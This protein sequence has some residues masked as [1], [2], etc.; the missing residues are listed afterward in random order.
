MKDDIDPSTLDALDGLDEERQYMASQGGKKGRR[1]K[2]PKGH[3]WLARWLPVE[4]GKAKTWYAR[5]G[6][7]WINKFPVLCPV[8]TSRHFG[9]D[10]DCE[11]K[12]CQ[13]SEELN[14]D[15]RKFVSTVGY[16]AR[17]VPQWLTYC[18]IFEKQDERNSDIIKGRD[19]WAPWEFWLYKNPFDD[20]A[21]MYDKGKRRDKERQSILDLETGSDIWVKSKQRGLSFDREDPSP[22]ANMDDPAKFDKIINDIWGQIHLPTFQVPDEDELEEYAEKLRDAAFRPQRDDGD[23]RGSSRYSEDDDDGD[24]RRSSHR[25]DDDDRRPSSGSRSS[26]KEDDDEAPRRRVDEDDGDDRKPTRRTPSAEDD[27]GDRRPTRRAADEDD[28]KPAPRVAPPT[29]RAPPAEAPAA[30]KEEDKDDIDY[31]PSKAP[32]AA[33][34]RAVSPPPARKTSPPPAA[35]TAAPP[36][37]RPLD[38]DDSV[39]PE[40]KDPAPAAADAPD[41]P[42]E[43]PPAVAPPPSGLS[44]RLKNTL[45]NINSR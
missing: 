29:R 22:I 43:A 44:G 9:G 11:C 31:S 33:P 2:I 38:E 17:A 45:K 25:D 30:E 40:D 1:V 42:D 12:L 16:R 34:T 19:R 37:S 6:F 5:Y 20:L 14:A 32:A 18:L 26:R 24:D 10:P 13:V 21:M 4:L 28:R 8:H 3:S 36:A 15:R 27:D 23:R 7:H 41:L 39:P 35:K